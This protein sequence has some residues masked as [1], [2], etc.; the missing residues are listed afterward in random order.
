MGGGKPLLLCQGDM[1]KEHGQLDAAQG[2]KI[3]LAGVRLKPP[4]RARGC[5]LTRIRTLF[6]VLDAPA[7]LAW[8]RRSTAPHH[9]AQWV[10]VTG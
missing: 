3:R 8:W 5:N 10:T 7:W 2:C 1:P 9:L 6:I 4:R